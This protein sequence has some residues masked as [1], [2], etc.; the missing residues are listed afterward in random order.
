MPTD[1]TPVW[2]QPEKLFR[3]LMLACLVGLGIAI[4]YTASHAGPL[5][6]QPVHARDLASYLFS[7]LLLFLFFYAQYRVVPRFLK[8]PLD[9]LLGLWHVGGSAGMLL[10]GAL[11]A[12][13]S[14]GRTDLPSILLFWMLLLG[15][16]LFLANVVWSYVKSEPVVPVLPTVGVT[17]QTPVPVR[18]DAAKNMGWPKSPAKLFG[19]GAGFFAAGGIVSLILNVPAY[20]IPVPISGQLHFLP[21]G[22]LWIAAALPFAIFALLYKVLMDAQNLQ[23]EED[24][25]N[26]IHF[27]T[28]I[29]AVIDLVRVFS[30]WQQAMVS[31]MWAM[32]FGPEF[33]WLAFLFGFSAVVFLINAVR[34][35]SRA[36]AQS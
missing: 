27:V 1:L 10:V 16:G 35:Y 13:Y 26:R 11:A 36:G 18:N 12:L 14:E 2:R 8:R 24:S 3:G 32:Y 34:A 4:I 23:F 7:A 30:G 6:E 31:K 19:I 21:F 17:R 28:T 15:E 25:L 20:Q 22:L 33:A 29:I 9:H 5:D